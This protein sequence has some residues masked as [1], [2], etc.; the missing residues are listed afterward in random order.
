M[1]K[2]SHSRHV[3]QS[4]GGISLII[5]LLHQFQLHFKQLEQRGAAVRSGRRQLAS[6]LRVHAWCTSFFKR[7]GLSSPS[8]NKAIKVSSLNA[9][10]NNVIDMRQIENTGLITVKNNFHA[11][12]KFP[13]LT[14]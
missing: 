10:F 1:V 6:A 2:L 8:R 13:A 14:M 4:D 12:S 7:G 11:S 9:K 5:T 3:P